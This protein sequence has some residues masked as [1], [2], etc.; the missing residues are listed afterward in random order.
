MGKPCGETCRKKCPEKISEERQSVV[1]RTYW[2]MTYME[3]WTFIFTMVSQ[4]AI[5][6]HTAPVPSR[7]GESLVY[8]LTDD[9]GRPQ[10]ICKAFF[11][12]TLGYHPKNDRLKWEEHK[13][14]AE[15]GRHHYRADAE[16]KE[17][18]LTIR[19]VDLQKVIMLPRMPGVKTAVFT[20]R[21]SAFHETFATARKKSATKKKSISV[22]WH[23]GIAGRKA[24][25][26]ASAYITALWKERNITRVICWLDNCTAQNKNWC[27]LTTLVSVVN[28]PTQA[29]KEVTLKYFEPGH[30]FMSADSFQHGVELEMK[31]QSGGAVLDF[32]DFRNV[33]AS[34]NSGKVE[35]VEL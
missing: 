23:E 30:T 4:R 7:R 8:H 15:A 14:R 31:R 33:V 21:I 5:K 16:R 24:E 20:K 13:G 34:S 35:V 6:R 11:L 22:I 25:E 17:A 28:D 3:K 26:V 29:V 32:E 9:L 19:S 27:L 2:T 1:H 18:D 12:T 10:D